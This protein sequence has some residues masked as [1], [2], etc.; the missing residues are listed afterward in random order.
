MLRVRAVSQG[1]TG[2]PGLSTFY[3][4]D[5]IAENS[6]RAGD[7]VGRVRSY[8]DTIKSCYDGTWTCQVSG[9]VD[10]VDPAT[11]AVTNTLS[12]TP[13]AVVNGSESGGGYLTTSSAICTS[14]QTSTF[15]A[16]RRLRGRTFNG[17]THRNTG[18]L[19]GS[20]VAAYLTIL[21]T[22]AAALRNNGA[23]TLAMV[24]W[25]RPVGGGGG[26]VGLVDGS[27]VKDK[28]AVLRSRRD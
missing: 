13:P 28:F 6:A 4:K 8:F 23:S 19:N 3:F 10:V 26:S 1:W 18:E 22:A 21:G 9:D 5:D 7:A 25:H 2:G 11:G 15:I 12:V 16:G 27:S 17:P 24:I 14:W 20:P